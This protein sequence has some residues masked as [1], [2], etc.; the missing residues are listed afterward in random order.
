MKEIDIAPYVIAA[1]IAKLG[2]DEPCITSYDDGGD[3]RNPFDYNNSEWTSPGQLFHH[4][5]HM[6][7][8]STLNSNFIAAPA[9][10]QVFRFFREQH[11]MDVVISSKYDNGKKYFY[12]IET[13]PTNG[14][15]SFEDG[16]NT[17]EE[18]EIACATKLIEL[19]KT[20]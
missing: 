15:Q 7:Q 20:K 3:L 9:W 18:A 10:S 11:N 14:L 6:V 16:F 2:F 17:Y 1:N 8:N 19:T 12:R 4:A 13:P 5:E